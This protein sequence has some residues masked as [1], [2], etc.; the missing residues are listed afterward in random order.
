ML[1][2]DHVLERISPH[3]SPE[4]ITLSTG[5]RHYLESLARIERADGIRLGLG[6]HQG[7]IAD[8]PG[9]AAA[10][11]R[12]VEQRL[13][14]VLL[15]CAE[16]RTIAEVSRHVFGPQRSYHVL[17]AL[18]ESGA[19]VEHLYQHGELIAANVEDVEARDDPVILYRRT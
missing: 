17:L 3:I 13:E 1:T 12:L 7:E 6:G 9:R 15:H 14:R 11:R 2:A 4:A 8:V 18:L 10:I 16:P 19:L 5:I